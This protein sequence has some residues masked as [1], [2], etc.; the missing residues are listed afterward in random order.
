MNQKITYSQAL[1]GYR[2]HANSRR[3][4][5]NTMNDYNLTFRKFASYLAAD[6]PLEQITA[7]DIEAFLASQGHLSKKTVSNLHTGLSSLWTWAVGRK[8]ASE[9]IVRQV[10]APKT[11][12]KVI[13]IF[14]EAEVQAI[15]NACARAQSYQRRGHTVPV[16]FGSAS[17]ATAGP[18]RSVTRPSSS[19]C[20]IQWPE[21]PNCARCAYR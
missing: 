5:Q 21:S 1:K 6:P 14:T 16:S 2:I 8:I 11:T 17:A 9:H 7:D 13:E 4:S 3:L 18:R 20:W 15:L 10:R 12:Q 19:L